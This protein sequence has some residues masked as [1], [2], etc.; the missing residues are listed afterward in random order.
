MMEKERTTKPPPL[1]HSTKT[2][3][4]F[5]DL[6]PSIIQTGDVHVLKGHGMP[7][8]KRASGHDHLD[9]RQ[10]GDLYV[11]Y[12]VEM[13]GSTAASSTAS[14][15]MNADNLSPEERV[16]LARLLSK[17][18]GSEDPTSH[19]IHGAADTSHDNGDNTA[20]AAWKEESSVENSEPRSSKMVQ[21]LAV[22]SAS[23][24]GQSPDSD[25][26]QDTGH[27]DDDDTDGGQGNNFGATEDVSEFFQ[28][29]FTGGNGQRAGGFGGPFGLGG[30]GGGGGGFHYFSS[31]NNG[32]GGRSGFGYSGGHHHGG[33]G[34]EEDH[35]VECNQM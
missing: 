21:H 2:T 16:E 18:D 11:Q 26:E 12:I 27:H 5:Y 10:F 3:S 15:V 30:T 1:E 32:G 17:L 29:A 31:S 6:P 4:A 8:T 24:F 19:V 20:T 23:D 28:R 25:N 14:K 34:E 13:P 22:A 35:K 33:G 9:Q 7:K